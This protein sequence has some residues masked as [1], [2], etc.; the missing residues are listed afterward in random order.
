MDV[1]VLVRAVES[2]LSEDTGDPQQDAKA[3]D[4]NKGRY[5]IG[6]PVVVRPAGWSWGY[7]ESKIKWDIRENKK[8][9]KDPRYTPVP[10]SKE[11]WIV[12]LKNV[13]VSVE[14]VQHLFEGEYKLMVAEKPLREKRRK[15]TFDLSRL[16]QHFKSELESE[17]Y[18]EIP[19]SAAKAFFRIKQNDNQA[20]V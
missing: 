12:R 9:N 7:G 4:T 11:F 14:E 16:P 2:L 19:W 1:D 6:D 13:D 8:K 3:F 10:Y 20:F 5:R 17:C 18:C 15:I